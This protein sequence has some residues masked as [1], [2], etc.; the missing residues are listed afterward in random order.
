MQVLWSCSHTPPL[1]PP[2]E[3]SQFEP[4]D[5]VLQASKARSG[6]KK[7]KLTNWHLSPAYW[8]RLMWGGMTL[9][10]FQPCSPGIPADP[11]SLSSQGLLSSTLR[12]SFPLTW[13]QTPQ[14]FPFAKDLQQTVTGEP[15]PEVKICSQ[16]FVNPVVQLEA[17]TGAYLI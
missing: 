2:L 1:H 11:P 10:V 16:F 5:K 15:K 17:G 12:P 3:L 13:D 6:E 4:S 7:H 8:L 14:H 9:L